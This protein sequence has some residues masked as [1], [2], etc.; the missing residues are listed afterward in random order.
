MLSASQA[1][2]F[3]LAAVLLTASPGP[4]NL[5]ALGLGM[6]RGRRAGIAFGLGCALGCLVHTALAVV[7]LGALAASSPMALTVLKAAGGAYLVWL[8]VQALRHAGGARL[9][10]GEGGGESLARL[11]GK[12]FLANAVNPKV[13]LFFL[14]F[15]PQ[16]V[17]GARG[18]VP[19]QMA[20]LGVIFTLQAAVLFGALGYFAGSVGAWLTRRPAAGR[21]LD[22]LAGVVFIA[23]GLRLIVAR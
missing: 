1:L 12:G 3:L 16:F 11:F 17:D 8:G 21:L 19:W 10:P 20:Q 4:D 23:L 5:M 18:D 6:S 13:L 7:G 14:S 15:L 9:A 22:R 2:A